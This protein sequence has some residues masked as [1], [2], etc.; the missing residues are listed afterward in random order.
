MLSFETA[1]TKHGQS[2]VAT[3]YGRPTSPDM[4]IKH[5]TRGPAT[6]WDGLAAEDTM[7]GPAGPPEHDSAQT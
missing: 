2:A 1:E 6:T 5:G 7:H 4:P 3:P